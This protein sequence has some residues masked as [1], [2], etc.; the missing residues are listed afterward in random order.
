MF[1]ITPED[2]K[3]AKEQFEDM[4]KRKE[5][6]S[7]PP[8][9]APN[10][11]EVRKKEKELNCLKSLLAYLGGCYKIEKTKQ[12]SPDFIISCNDERIGVEHTSIVNAN[13]DTVFIEKNILEKV[14]GKITLDFPEFKFLAE[15]Y[16]DKGIIINKSNKDSA[17]SELYERIIGNINPNEKYYSIDCESSRYFTEITIMIHNRVSITLN[18]GAGYAN[19]VTKDDILATI[20]KKEK[21]WINTNKRLVRCG[22]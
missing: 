15:V 7:S 19:D 21:K 10:I 11:R 14:K 16:I 13:K 1:T 6:I 4:K 3:N 9:D 8:I 2:L 5:N 22:Y 12:V 17:C 20:K 18:Y